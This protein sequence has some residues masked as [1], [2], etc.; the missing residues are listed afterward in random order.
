MAKPNATS[1]PTGEPTFS[2]GNVRV[3]TYQLLDRMTDEEIEVAETLGDLRVTPKT[4]RA[5]MNRLFFP[6]DSQPGLTAT[7]V[8]EGTTTFRL[9]N[10]TIHKLDAQGRLIP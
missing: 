7:E 2:A 9:I 1:H 5:R 8:A 3:G 6:K 4:V 10:T